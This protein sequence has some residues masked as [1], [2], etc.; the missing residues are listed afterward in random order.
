MAFDPT[1]GSDI[2]GAGRD[3]TAPGAYESPLASPAQRKPT[4]I[5]AVAGVE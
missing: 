4:C 2:Y 3:C 1:K 5:S